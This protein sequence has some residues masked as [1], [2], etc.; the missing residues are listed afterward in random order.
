[1]KF[2][3]NIEESLVEVEQARLLGHPPPTLASTFP[4]CRPKSSLTSLITI[5]RSC[6]DIK[7]LFA[8]AQYRVR[9]YPWARG[10]FGGY[11]AVKVDASQN[12]SNFFRDCRYSRSQDIYMT[13]KSAA[14]GRVFPSV[15]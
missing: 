9:L 15:P 7:S 11:I 4:T 8:R 5:W 2:G 14:E 6:E 1:M 3:L 12:V 10:T 13:G